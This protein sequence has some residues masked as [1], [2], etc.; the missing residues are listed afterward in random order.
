MVNLYFSRSIEV[1]RLELYH[2][3]ACRKHFQL[4]PFILGCPLCNS[5]LVLQAA[6]SREEA[7]VNK[8]YHALSK[9]TVAR[10]HQLLCGFGSSQLRMYGGAAIFISFTRTASACIHL[11]IYINFYGE[12]RNIIIVII[13]LNSK[14]CKIS[15]DNKRSE[16]KLTQFL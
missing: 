4:H 7:V 10:P 13:V 5:G 9:G 6:L 15:K 1:M 16:F 3:I 8:V 2:A 11:L 14:N 12:D